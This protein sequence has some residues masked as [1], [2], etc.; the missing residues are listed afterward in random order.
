VLER[1]AGYQ[2]RLRNL[3]LKAH[4]FLRITRIL[5]VRGL[6]SGV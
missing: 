2:P 1:T 5:K 4:N 6:G 3:N